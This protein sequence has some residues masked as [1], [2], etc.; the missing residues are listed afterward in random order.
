MVQK[1]YKMQMIKHNT[2]VIK[3]IVEDNITGGITQEPLQ[4]GGVLDPFDMI[5]VG[6][7][8]RVNF[9]TTAIGDFLDICGI[10]G[11]A[12]TG[13][14][15]WYGYYRQMADGGTFTGGAADALNTIN[16]GVMH[17]NSINAPL[18]KVATLSSTVIPT[19]D[20]TNLP[21]AFTANATAPTITRDTIGFIG[22][23]VKRNGTAIPAQ[24]WSFD[25]GAN[26][27]VVG[28]DGLPYDTEAFLV[29]RAPK[30]T[31]PIFD[32]SLLTSSGAL[33]GLAGT[34]FTFYLRKQ[35]LGGGSPVAD[36]TAEH[37]K[38]TITVGTSYIESVTS[39]NTGLASVNL[40]IV[41]I[42]N[43]TNAI[44]IISTAS[45]IT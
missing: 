21:C 24:G 8:P 40:V 31:I 38:F 2:T 13:S 29:S 32:M 12:I 23:P 44:V 17:I 26:Y 11:L 25:L 5:T 14:A 10:D 4:G 36:A 9:V 41:P 18:N 43:V 37:I 19:Y 30:F 33:A 7:K 6:S 27:Q 42:Y 3:G 22:G 39:P 20:G 16:K 34:N 15:I 28:S 35:T 1:A 45:A